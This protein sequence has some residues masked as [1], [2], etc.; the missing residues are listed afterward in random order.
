[1]K[2]QPCVVGASVS[3]I[4]EKIHRCQRCTGLWSLEGQAAFRS[5][6]GL[7]FNSLQTWKIV[8]L[9]YTMETH[10]Y[11]LKPV[12]PVLMAE[13]A[14][15]DGSECGFDVTPLW[16]RRQAYH[17]YLCG[18]HHTYGHNDSW[19][20]LPTWKGHW[21]HPGRFKWAFSKGFS[22]IARNGGISFP[23]RPYLPVG[24]IPTDRC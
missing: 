4:S 11:N 5:C 19:R 14:Y 18:G 23:T 21:T 8:E 24:G 10:D 2:P 7:D 17:S 13:G 3:G 16:I 12:K 6:A 9:I 1:M 22:W 15:E 20:V